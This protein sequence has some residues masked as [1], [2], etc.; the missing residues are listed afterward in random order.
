MA[1]KYK[2]YAGKLNKIPEQARFSFY[3]ANS[4]YAL[5]F[6]NTEPPKGFVLVDSELERFLKK[7]EKEWVYKCK[8]TLHT[9][10]LAEHSKEYSRILTEYANILEKELEAE[11]K[12][13]KKSV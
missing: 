11:Y 12:K 3:S 9:E 4:T 1:A 13:T 6:I 10:N 5:I 8:M 2:L 7:E